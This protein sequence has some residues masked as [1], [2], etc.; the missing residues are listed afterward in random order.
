MVANRLKEVRENLLISK[1]E[2][3]RKAG[4]S[5]LTIARVEKGVACRQETKRKIL[6]AL[7]LKPWEK[8]QIF[9]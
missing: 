2:L 4:I 6:A 5:Q 7:G 1:S 3:A 9:P 8:E